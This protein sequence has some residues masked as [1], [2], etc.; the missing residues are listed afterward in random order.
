M[1]VTT[2]DDAEPQEQPVPIGRHPIGLLALGN[3][4][5]DDFLRAVNERI[6][7]PKAF[8]DITMYGEAKPARKK[9]IAGEDARSSIEVAPGTIEP[10]EDYLNTIS[11][12]GSNSSGD[13]EIKSKGFNAI[14][15][16]GAT[17]S[18]ISLKTLGRLRKS[19]TRFENLH[20]DQQ[21]ELGD[22]KKE[23]SKPLGVTSLL[24]YL[25]T[26]P[27]V[28]FNTTFWVVTSCDTDVVLGQDV[29]RAAVLAVDEAKPQRPRR[30]G[31]RTLVGSVNLIAHKV[32]AGRLSRHSS[33]YE[34]S[35]LRQ[36]VIRAATGGV[37][38]HV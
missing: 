12:T 24:W 20:E 32:S 37:T 9:P 34:D 5:P 28:I 25:D 1:V 36:E 35:P 15:D 29:I 21:I 2:E 10:R 16:T 3:V 7:S 17:V 33:H 11:D 27:K 6:L 26:F 19:Y 8:A 23:V 38:P 22:Y 14:Y 31:M 30:R 18:I 13:S 4:N